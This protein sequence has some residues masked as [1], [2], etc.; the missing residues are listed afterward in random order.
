MW[1]RLGKSIGPCWSSFARASLLLVR[2]CAWRFVSLCWSEVAHV[3]GTMV[4][5]ALLLLHPETLPS[6]FY[7]EWCRCWEMWGWFG[8]GWTGTNRNLSW[9]S[10]SKAHNVPFEAIRHAARKTPVAMIQ[11]HAFIQSAWVTVLLL[12][13]A[14]ARTWLLGGCVRACP[15]LMP[16][17]WMS[18]QG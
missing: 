4:G 5:R 7:T 12:K 17:T 9:V 1:R 10:G 6:T 18:L 15:V 14:H 2:T 8:C 11:K 13:V 16:K 3:D